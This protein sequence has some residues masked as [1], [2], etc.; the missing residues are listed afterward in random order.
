[1]VGA[2]VTAGVR[3]ATPSVR[4]ARP[5]RTVVG[6]DKHVGRDAVVHPG[7]EPAGPPTV[8]VDPATQ[9]GAAERAA[10]EGLQ[11][12]AE[13]RLP[14]RVVGDRGRSVATPRGIAAA[15]VV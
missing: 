12:S 1:V 10:G 5:D 15:R 13:V 7:G 14:L 8:G 9:L 11:D 3:D 2:V 6:L 4:V